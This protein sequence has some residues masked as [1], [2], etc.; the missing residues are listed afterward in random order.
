[1]RLFIFLILCIFVGG[2]IYLVGNF[3]AVIGT[4]TSF[5]CDLIC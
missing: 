5:I 2:S 1:M 3:G 4:F